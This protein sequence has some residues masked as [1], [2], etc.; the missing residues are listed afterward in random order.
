MLLTLAKKIS[1]ATFEK[2]S[3]KAPPVVSE[4]NLSNT[5]GLLNHSKII[6][7]QGRAKNYLI[8]STVKY[9]L[10]CHLHIL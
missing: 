9:T 1:C 2:K 8:A 3:L 5:L 10:I 6:L 4:L 7:Q